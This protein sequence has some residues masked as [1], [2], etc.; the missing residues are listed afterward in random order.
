MTGLPTFGRPSIGQLPALQHR[1]Y[2]LF[3]GGQGLSLIGTWMT[4]VAQSWLVL[5]LTGS[6][7][8]LGL[9]GVF[10][11]TPVLILGLFGGIIAD[12]L[13]KR[14][15]MY[16]TQ[17]I[18]MIVSFILFALSATHT[19]QLWHVYL[20]AVIMGI[21]NAVDMPT[22]QAFAVE[23]VGRED[24]GN[25]VALNSSMFNGARIVG[26][27]IAGLVIGAFSQGDPVGG[28]APAF[29]IDA[30]SFLAVLIALFAMDPE[31]L[32]TAPRIERPA[33]VGAIAANLAEGLGYVR[34][35]SVVLLAVVIVGIVATFGINF[36]IVLP[37]LAAGPLNV[38]AAGYGFLMAASG[39]GS[40]VAAL[41][42]AFR[43]T[44]PS[45]MLAGALLLG[46]AEMVVGASRSFGLDLAFMFLTGTGA[47]TM[48]A[49]ANT[50]MQLAVPD[51]LRGRVM[52]V[53]TTVFAGSTPIGGLAMGAIAANLGADV[54]LFSGGLVSL[55]AGLAGIVWYRRLRRSGQIP[56]LVRTS[57]AHGTNA[58]VVAGAAATVR[59]GAGPA[60]DLASR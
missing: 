15:T 58:R 26:P 18:A 35:T 32:R 44:K 47:I 29:L 11:F 3:F 24:V 14:S 50:T 48:M 4:S 13:P 53:Y 30:I 45:R 20:L 6:A 8:D 36:S 1:N 25:A 43:G 40:L 21:R 55:L 34:R 10:Q 5:Q 9:I 16:A 33:T 49:T 23:M 56:A 54:A 28:V 57:E 27:A 39:A 2:R 59:P 51:G 19:V 37:P 46:A 38:G 31:T 7:F 12:S 41:F 42:I 52:S 17:T 22:R 60:G